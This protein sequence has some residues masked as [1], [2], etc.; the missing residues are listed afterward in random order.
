M[1]Y[2]TLSQSPTDGG[3]LLLGKSDGGKAT[4]R[5]SDHHQQAR[6]LKCA[7]RQQLKQMEQGFKPVTHQLQD[8]APPHHS[9]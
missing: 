3:K 2:I 8:E 6:W 5:P 1:P 4:T 7:S 9:Y